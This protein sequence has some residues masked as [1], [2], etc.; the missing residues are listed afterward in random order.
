M[1]MKWLMFRTKHV[2][3]SDEIVFCKLLE[4][5]DSSLENDITARI[6]TCLA[7]TSGPR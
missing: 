4:A 6:S 5:R 3:A 1:E 2:F 7:E